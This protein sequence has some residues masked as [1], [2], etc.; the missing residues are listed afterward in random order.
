MAADASVVLV[1]A[2]NESVARS[3]V[4]QLVEERVV[5]CGT[6]V[7]GVTSIYRWEGDV[8]EDTETLVVANGPFEI[9]KQPNEAAS[10]LQSAQSLSYGLITQ[11]PSSQKHSTRFRSSS[12][13][14]TTSA[15]TMSAV[16]LASA[17]PPPGPR[18]AS[19]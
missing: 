11:L 4:R 5:A 19:R 18:R 9:T 2:P 1:T 14:R 12:M 7:P 16:G 13:S 6:V 10:F 8:Q 17:M 15:M 3:L